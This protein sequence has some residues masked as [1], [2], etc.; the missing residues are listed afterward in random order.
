MGKARV[1][2]STEPKSDGFKK[3][4]AKGI[5]DAVYGGEMLFSGRQDSVPND[6]F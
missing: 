5:L 1:N 2:A 4:A 6:Q 3:I